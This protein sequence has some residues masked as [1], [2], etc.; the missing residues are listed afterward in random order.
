MASQ[1][2]VDIAVQAPHFRLRL[3]GTLQLLRDDVISAHGIVTLE[4]QCTLAL[5]C[6]SVL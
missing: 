1:R 6:C 2:M 5:A 3:K 4:M